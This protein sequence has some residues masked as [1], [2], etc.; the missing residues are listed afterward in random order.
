MLG[1]ARFVHLLSAAAF[2][3]GRVEVGI[4]GGQPQLLPSCQPKVA[5]MPERWLTPVALTALVKLSS[6]YVDDLVVQSLP[7]A[8]ERRLTGPLR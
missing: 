6:Q 4:V 2:G 1:P 8:G 5:S 3:L 7:I